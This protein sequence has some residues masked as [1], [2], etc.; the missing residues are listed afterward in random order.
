MRRYNKQLGITKKIIIVASP[1]VQENF[2]LQLFDERKLILVN[3]FW[4]LKSCV[5]NKFIKEINP[6]NMKGLDKATVVKQI[7]KIISQSY[8][9]YGYIEFSKYINKIMTKVGNLTN[10]SS[11]Q[12]KK[13]LF[14]LQRTNLEQYS[15][16]LPDG[17]NHLQELRL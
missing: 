3:G 10:S 4:N 12:F 13:Q 9:F 7:K 6:M 5:G 11:G 16:L 1:G 2:K 14:Y 8:D 17:H 15:L